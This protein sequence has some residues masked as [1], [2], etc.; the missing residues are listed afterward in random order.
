MD[1]GERAIHQRLRFGVP[2]VGVG[3]AA[4]NGQ[5]AQFFFQR[6]QAIAGLLADHLTEELAE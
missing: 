4:A 1:G 6:I 5:L 2:T 3:L